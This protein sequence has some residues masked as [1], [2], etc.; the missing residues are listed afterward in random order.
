MSDISIRE[1]I[2]WA[3]VAGAAVC[4]IAAAAIHGG[5]V[6]AF[7]AASGSFSAAAAMWGYTNRPPTV[8]KA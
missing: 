6:E 3:L 5:W 4:G 2:G 1:R 7:T 8:T